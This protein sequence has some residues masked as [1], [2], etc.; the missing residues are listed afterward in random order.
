MDYNLQTAGFINGKKLVVWNYSEPK[1]SDD[2]LQALKAEPIH[3]IHLI[4][5][6]GSMYSDIDQLCEDIKK[7]VTMLE[8]DDLLSVIYFASNGQEKV[9]LK[10][11]HKKTKNLDVLIN[12]MKST[13][14]AT[15][16]SAPLK[17]TEEVVDE[18]KLLC[19]KYVVTLFTD[20]EPVVPWSDSEEYNR[21]YAIADR[22]KD[23]VLMI[24]TIG[25]GYYYNE[26][27]LR[28]LAERTTFGKYS[29]SENIKDFAIIFERNALIVK[30]C[31]AA[32]IDFKVKG[33]ALFLTLKDIKHFKDG[34]LK[35]NYIS[36]YRNQCVGIIDA[37]DNEIII[38][39]EVVILD[40]T[41]K[42]PTPTLNNILYALAS[43]YASNNSFDKALDVMVL[44]KDKF[45][46]DKLLN[47]FTKFER[48]ALSDEL[49][50]AYIKNKFRMQEGEAPEGYIPPEDVFNIMDL[51][52]DFDAYEVK[53]V[54]T[55]DYQRIGRKV[56]ESVNLFK[57]SDEQ[58]YGHFS[59]LVYS[60]EKLNISIRFTINGIVNIPTD[61]ADLAGLPSKYPSSIYRV[62]TLVKD[63]NVHQKQFTINVTDIDFI[64]KYLAD[65]GIP[66]VAED[67]NNLTIDITNV[68]ITNRKKAKESNIYVILNNVKNAL[69]AKAKAKVVKH[70]LAEEK[71]IALTEG[72]SAIKFSPE[73]AAVLKE[74]GVDPYTRIYSGVGRE[75]STID[76]N[77]FYMAREI[78][79]GIKGWSASPSVKDIL[80]GKKLTGLG[81]FMKEELDNMGVYKTKHPDSKS[82][83]KFLES[84]LA[85]YNKE[86][87][88]NMT[89]VAES[90]ISKIVAGMWWEE[91]DLQDEGK[92]ENISQDGTT[93]VVKSAM[94]KIYF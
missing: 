94:T 18:L 42:I 4:D 58:S 80:A 87:R 68:P 90:K 65:K 38:D 11:A 37:L 78:S 24:N 35:L 36:K 21:C 5:R 63:G 6:S 27:F 89:E 41:K 83:I 66:I 28:N 56:T 70:F 88:T 17:L 2:E 62:H 44:L 1:M 64:K 92:N 20:G 51:F 47:V 50:K 54:P 69:I 61:K 55:K 57:A 22:L 34:H 86:S 10:G 91:L 43:A 84:L 9:L 81:A 33:E 73:Q 30:D 75:T 12:S 49:K 13:I 77:D 82:L 72:T 23:K 7:T 32:N 52:R 53:Y 29:H 67:G 14:G 60:E 15:C 59:D 25:Y 26:E 8:D 93:L 16:F 46:I 74:C 76:E 39:G 48:N 31:E 71:A 45:F 40:N 85:A 19:D 3:F 79:F